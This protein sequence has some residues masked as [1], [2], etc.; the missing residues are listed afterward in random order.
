MKK[1]TAEL[2]DA[3]CRLEQAAARLRLYA[4]G[5]RQK[6]ASLDTPQLQKLLEKAIEETE[7]IKSFS[8]DF[9]L[10]P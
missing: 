5:R 1:N 4:A 9:D 7:N 2:E 10:K 8:K 6:G 3:I